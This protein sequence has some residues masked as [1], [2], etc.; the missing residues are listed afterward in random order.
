MFKL[1][2]KYP[3]LLQLHLLMLTGAVVF[4]YQLVWAKIVS[5]YIQKLATTL[6][7]WLGH[8]IAAKSRANKEW[9]TLP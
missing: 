3:V 7:Q 5:Y 4:R 6:A 8:R 9:I 1:Y 2:F